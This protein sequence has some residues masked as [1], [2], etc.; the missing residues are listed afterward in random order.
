MCPQKDVVLGRVLAEQTPIA[1][2][3]G[4]GA[5]SD[6]GMTPQV[7]RKVLSAEPHSGVQ[8]GAD[9][10]I[11]SH[12]W[13]IPKLGIR[14]LG[15]DSPL[16]FPDMLPQEGRLGGGETGRV[17]ILP[18]SP[19]ACNRPDVLTGAPFS[20]AGPGGPCGP[21]LPG[22][23]M[24]PA[25]PAGPLSPGEPCRKERLAFG[26]AQLAWARAQLLW[27]PQNMGGLCPHHSRSDSCLS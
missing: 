5:G 25:A 23:P 15:K 2:V 4:Y 11:G 1:D 14:D 24:G 3:V 6:A 20:P 17:V 22:I 21:G 10:A 9:S 19:S 16:F 8:D 27:A 18:S 7:P 12:L 26:R 13:D